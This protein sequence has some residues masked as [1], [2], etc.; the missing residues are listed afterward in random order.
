MEDRG[1]LYTKLEEEIWTLQT[2]G[3]IATALGKGCQVC[4]RGTLGTSQL[5]IC[6]VKEVEKE[7]EVLLRM[8]AA[9]TPGPSFSFAYP[10]LS[11]GR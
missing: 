10:G 6:P 11:Q 4:G 3:V 2:F 9:D 1:R 5:E 8:W 7:L